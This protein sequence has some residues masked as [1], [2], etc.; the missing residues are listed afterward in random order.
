[1]KERCEIFREFFPEGSAG[2][3]LF[4]RLHA[5]A[6]ETLNRERLD[7]EQFGFE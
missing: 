3:R 7:D 4:D 1:M 6:V 2:R 5:A